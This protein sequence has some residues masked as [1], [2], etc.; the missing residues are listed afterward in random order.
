MKQIMSNELPAL[1]GSAKQIAWANDIRE[2]CVSAFNAAV[3]MGSTPTGSVLF[4]AEMK[5]LT[6]LTN[7]FG[8][9]FFAVGMS[10]LGPRCQAVAVANEKACGFGS[11]RGL[12]KKE[13]LDHLPEL[14]RAL[15]DLFTNATNSKTY[16]DYMRNARV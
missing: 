1:E 4:P 14:E 13:Q 8:T 16:I 9:I 6:A 2:K 11:G 12:S 5:E 3:E 7:A 15:Y 10:K